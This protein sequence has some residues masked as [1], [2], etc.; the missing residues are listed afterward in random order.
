MNYILRRKEGRKRDREGG[1][2]RLAGKGKI[3]D[4]D[5][6][7]VSFWSSALF[8]PVVRGAGFEID[9]AEHHMHLSPASNWGDNHVAS[10]GRRNFALR[11]E[12]LTET[13][14]QTFIK[15]S[16]EPFPD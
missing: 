14:Y 10:I 9:C 5:A 16:E 13:S 8:I 15:H 3:D 12:H 2:D 7:S 11:M 1:R 6:D 4:V